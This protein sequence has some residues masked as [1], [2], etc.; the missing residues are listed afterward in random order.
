MQQN[1]G[2]T[3]L[4]LSNFVCETQWDDIPVD[5][6]HEA[7]RSILNFFACALAGCRDP[8]VTIAT[9]LYRRYS[10]PGDC[11]VVGTGESTNPL[12][13]AALNAMSANVFDFDDTHLP[14]FIHP[15]APV[16]PAVFAVAQVRPMTGREAILAFVLGV[17]LECRLG[18]ALSPSHYARG[19]H[20][21]STC[22]IFGAAAA[23]AR[24]LKLDAQ[25][26]AWAFGSASAQASG[27]VETVGT[28]SKSLGIGHSASNGL[29][30]A[31]LAGEGYS[32]PD[33]PLEG[34]RAFLP[35]FGAGVPDA[36]RLGLGAAGNCV[37]TAT[38]PTLAIWS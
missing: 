2:S 26:T 18:L 17:E 34:P 7:K 5:V 25:A 6:H 16:A 33:S 9:R 37:P 8:A 36:L 32:G 21:T 24:G 29:L 27:L 4:A 28:M 1:T 38:S 22:G 3:T 10:S 11:T 14:T 13:A 30:S 20:I 35:V 12:H 19:W 23:A 31:L 15:T